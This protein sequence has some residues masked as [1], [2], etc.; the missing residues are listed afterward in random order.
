MV[1]ALAVGNPVPPRVEELAPGV[2][3]VIRQEPLGLAG[4]ANSLLIIGDSDVIVVDAQFTREATNET[5]AAIRRLTRHPVSVVINTHWHDDHLAGD[6]VYR[7]TFPGV[8]FVMQANT[9]VDL[10]TLGAENRTSQIR[11]APPTAGRFERL[12]GMGLGI[13]STAVSALE[14]ASVS[15]AL[16]II[17]QYVA[18]AP[19][20]RAMTADDTVQHRLVLRRGRRAIDVRWFGCANTR[21]D[22]V[23]YLPAEGVI[24]TGDLVV[25]PIP[26][27]FNSYPSGWIGALDS[28]IDLDPRMLVPGHGPVMRDL[29]YVR[30]VRSLLTAARDQARAAAARGDSLAQAIRTVTLDDDRRRLAGDEKWMNYLFRSYFLHPVV[31]RAYEEVAEHP[32]AGCQP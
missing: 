12:L 11:Y 7:D 27:G 32:A 29:A 9:A 26:F 4:N 3:A 13:D 17:R 18:E 21:G 25:A 31:A 1:A 8:R 19:G 6:Q 14:R 20:F 16:R 10:A 15:S 28:V 24:A 5:I 23:V 30:T 2:F 22:V